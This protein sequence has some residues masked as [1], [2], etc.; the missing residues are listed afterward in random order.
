MN[1]NPSCQRCPLHATC[2][3]VCIPG[4]GPVP[5]DF[6]LVGEAPGQ[7]EDAEGRNFIGK[8]GRKLR[9]LL[10]N[11]WFDPSRMRIVNALRC[12]PPG[13]REPKAVELN[14]CVLYLEQEIAAVQPKWILAVGGTA[15]KAL[16]GKAG[17][18]RKRGEIHRVSLP[19]SGKKDQ[20]RLD[21]PRLS[22]EL[23]A[24]IKVFPVYHTSFVLREPEHEETLAKDL[25]Y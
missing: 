18:L 11:A 21:Q 17:I 4:E 15:L 14:A 10:E 5:A 1:H 16:T 8:T 22:D 9:A 20:E 19:K 7:E 12:R 3:T 25:T 23:V 2:Q 13:N 24:S 6:L